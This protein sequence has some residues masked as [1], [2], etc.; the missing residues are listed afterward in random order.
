M[1]RSARQQRAR[2]TCESPGFPLVAPSLAPSLGTFR[3]PHARPTNTPVC[4]SQSPS[5]PGPQRNKPITVLCKTEAARSK[6]ANFMLCSIEYS[7]TWIG[8]VY[9]QQVVWLDISEKLSF[10]AAEQLTPCQRLRA[11]D[12]NGFGG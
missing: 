4:S 8:K 6:S 10:T 1:N 9:I 12:T 2:G 11:R 3:L 7:T 5:E